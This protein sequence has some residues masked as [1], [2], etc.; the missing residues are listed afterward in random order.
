MIKHI[1]TTEKLRGNQYGML[2]KHGKI[3]RGYSVSID[4]K[5]ICENWFST[6]RGSMLAAELAKTGLTESDINGIGDI[7][8]HA[9]RIKH[10]KREQGLSVADSVRFL[11]DQLAKAS[12]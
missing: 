5:I 6:L 8:A 11:A 7:D 4:G 2:K 1:K 9:E 3:D 12:R 10:V